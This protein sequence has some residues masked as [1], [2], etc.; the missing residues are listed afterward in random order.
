M[1]KQIGTSMTIFFQT[2]GGALVVA[3]SQSVYANDFTKHV[4]SL[5]IPDQEKAAILAAGVTGFRHFV[6]EQAL[7]AVVHLSVIAIRKALIFVPV[8]T[9]LAL[10]ATIPLPWASIRG[11]TPEVAV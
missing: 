7:P 9:G 2:L 5:A 10:L 4:A 1:V 3:A 6:S 8:F 11:P